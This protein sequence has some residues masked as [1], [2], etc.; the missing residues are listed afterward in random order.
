MIVEELSPPTTATNVTPC[1]PNGLRCPACGGALGGARISSEDRL[2]GLP[3]LFSLACCATCGIGVTLPAVEPVDLPS[4]YPRTYGTYESLPHGVLGLLSALIQRAQGWRALGTAPLERLAALPAGRLLDVGC[5]RGDLGAWFV[6]RG[7]VVVGVEPSQDAC[8]VASSRGVDARAGT[9]ADVALEAGAFDAVVFRQS[10][11]HVTDPVGDLRRARE[12]LGD[13]GV[14]IVS[15]PNFGCWQSRRF[16]GRWF[17]LDLPRHR[18]HFNASALRGV[19]TDAGF[20]HVEISTSSSAIGLPASIQ[21]ALAGRCLFRRGLKLRIAVALCAPIAP[22]IRL[23]DQ[24]A[25]EGDTLHAVAS[26]D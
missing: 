10:L 25:G 8:A 20:S 5:G 9:L 19:L 3:G 17:H 7:W 14:V 4:L 23:L 22:L 16:G 11:E 13:G 21:Y 18:F 6:R 2:C 26:I 24:L 15:V 1:E 12:A